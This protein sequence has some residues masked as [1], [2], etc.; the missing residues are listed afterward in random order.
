M[1]NSF[2][3]EGP[4]SKWTNVVNGWQYRWFVLDISLGV[5]SYY[6]SKEKMMRGDRRGCVKLK[7]AQ[8]GIDDEDDS[9]FT[10]TVD[11]KTFHFQARNSDERQKWL[12]AL[13]EARDLHT[14]NYAL[15]NQQ[16]VSHI[17]S[18]D[19]CRPEIM[20][21]VTFRM[22]RLIELVKK[23]IV[24]LQFARGSV[25]GSYRIPITLNDNTVSDVVD[26]PYT[27][28]FDTSRSNSAYSTLKVKDYDLKV[29]SINHTFI[30]AQGGEGDGENP[31]ASCQE[32]LSG[33]SPIITQKPSRK[34][35]TRN[36]RR[37][38]KGKLHKRPSSTTESSIESHSVY[39]H[40]E[41]LATISSSLPNDTVI[42]KRCFDALDSPS[43][44]YPPLSI[45]RMPVRSYS[46]SDDDEAQLD[47]EEEDEEF[48]DT[49]EDI[50]VNCAITNSPQPVK[51]NTN[52][53]MYSNPTVSLTKSSRYLPSQSSNN[54]TN[55]SLDDTFDE[56]YDD[57]NEEELGSVQ[58]H[59]SVITHLLSQLRIG[60]DLTRITLPTFILE[61][62]S[63]LEMYADFLAHADLWAVIPNGSTPRDRMVSCL[64][65]YL[66]A[67]HA[68]RRSSVAKKPYNPTLGEIFRC[69]W[70]LSKESG[71]DSSN[72]SEKPQD[73]LCNSGPVPWA[74][75]NSVVFLAEQVS[76][77]PPISAFYAEHVN[78]QIAVDGHLWTKSK[79]LG[80]S[81][82]V[83]MVGSA[84]IS[85]LN[86]DE[87]Y[88][89]TF[90]CGYGRNILTVPWIELGGKTSITCLKTGYLANIEFRTKPFYG[91]KRDTLRAEVFG[92]N[93]K[94]PFLIVEG[95]WNDKMLAKWSHGKSELF[96]DT[97]NI[98]TVR[99]HVLPRSRQEE[100]ESRRLWEEVTYNLKVGNI[101]A[102]S[103]AKHR[104]EQRQRDL[105]R[106]RRD[107]K[108]T[109]TP[110][111]FRGE[112]DNWI[113]RHPLI[114][115][116]HQ[117]PNQNI[118]ST[119][120]QTISKIM[121]L[122]CSPD[123][124]VNPVSC[125]SPVTDSLQI[126]HNTTTESSIPVIEYSASP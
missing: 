37:L 113:Y 99:K 98:S 8:V 34:H 6:T 10:I 38:E 115:R 27:L 89:V 80:L 12:D 67:F 106:Q 15:L 63:T 61:R 36:S 35:S 110:E 30:N 13:Q 9:T 72:A 24:C 32:S 95:E 64:R 7:N 23:T 94:K 17:P 44:N 105:A 77:H 59:G 56:L 88:V 107:S 102:A 100:N 92:P 104:L 51:D 42:V 101:D 78:N 117:P 96:I 75:N 69:Y 21:A 81:I 116:L 55:S 53:N 108:H 60:M 118:S 66:S 54:Q 121:N 58:S 19:D 52:I 1:D 4:L 84:V 112:G 85:L 103:D 70:P 87:E 46:S 109:W 14:Q 74:P 93:D 50:S 62:R 79:F 83:E 123:I 45:P 41:Q 49:Q 11:H 124:V 31:F 26:I 73:K 71:D 126:V 90:P 33:A 65:W 68:G 40:P 111:Y 3:M 25:S 48:F 20:G 120:P 91:G 28:H 43:A 22:Q 119:E 47:Q 122:A 82:A 16:L 76:H 57:E 97:R 18:S 39:S 125:N 5:L 86:H 2:M 29:H 114:Q